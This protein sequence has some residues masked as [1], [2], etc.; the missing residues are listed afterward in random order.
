MNTDK[1]T[2]ILYQI[3]LSNI[4][5]LFLFY[6]TIFYK[7]DGSNFNYKL[8]KYDTESKALNAFKDFLKNRKEDILSQHTTIAM[9]K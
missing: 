5:K 2:N 9:S 1:T 8:L 6:D 7:I 4:S 3:N